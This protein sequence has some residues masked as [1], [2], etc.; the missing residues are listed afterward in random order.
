MVCHATAVPSPVERPRVD[1]GVVTWNTRD[2]TV[3]AL[4][5]LLDS[6]QGCELRLLV[7]DNASTD[8]TVSALRAEVPEAAVEV[9]TD[10]LGFAAGVNR[11]LARSEAPWFL[12]LN[13]DAWP[14][15]G[16][17]GR[18]VEAAERHPRAA[19]VAPRLERPDGALEHS[20][21]PFP[22]VQV[23]AFTAVGGPRWWKSRARK[24]FIEGAW[25]HD[26]ETQVDWAVGAAWLMRRAAIDEIGGL[27]ERYFMYVE[28]VDWCHRAIQRGWEV[29]FTPTAVVR[30]VG[31]ASGVQLFANRRTE[32]HLRNAYTFYRG[33]HGPAS[34]AAY[35]AFNLVGCARLYAIARARGRH[36]DAAYWA[37]HVRVHAHRR[38]GTPTP[39]PPAQY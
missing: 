30:H 33:T 11:L 24:L 35:R 6:D 20:T 31:N 38:D 39:P 3:R 12:T 10:N 25:P 27:D 16:A 8:D 29:W 37:Q 36:A 4:R 18:L 15:P 32:T 34:T 14:E 21:Y 1:V 22:S 23:A 7:H 17:I 26:I 13:S 19:L 5:R 2:L 9:S 28:D